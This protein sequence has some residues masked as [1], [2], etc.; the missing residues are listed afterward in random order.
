MHVRRP[1]DRVPRRRAGTQ[2]REH[3][4]EPIRATATIA[5]RMRPRC[6]ASRS[7]PSLAA[8]RFD[9]GSGGCWALRVGM[10][11]V[12]LESTP[13][14]RVARRHLVDDRPWD[15]FRAE[16][17]RATG[18][19]RVRAPPPR[20]VL[21]PT[22]ATARLSA[23]SRRRDT[24]A[25]RARRRRSRCHDRGPGVSKEMCRTSAGGWSASSRASRRRFASRQGHGRCR[26]GSSGTHAHRTSTPRATESR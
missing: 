25:L 19:H 8:H 11:G 2:T 14:Y 1:V 7:L 3:R 26:A 15:A 13:G 17:V 4:Q 22:T 10:L 9:C 5:R 23:S 21:D 24:P 20:A 18:P 12:A 6:D 16:R